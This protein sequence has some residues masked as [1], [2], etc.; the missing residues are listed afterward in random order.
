MPTASLVLQ[1]G[2][3]LGGYRILDVIGFGG[4]AVVYRAEQV[5]LNRIVALKVLSPELSRDPVFQERFRRE[6]KHVAA[7][8]H[9]NIIPIYDAAESDGRL[10]LAMR[11]VEGQTLAQ[12]MA[13]GGIG[14]DPTL[15][16][17]TP[18]AD[19]L[20]TAHEASVI[21]RDIKP[22]N[23]LLT[24]RDHPFLADF[25]VAKHVAGQGLTASGSF[26]GSVS[27][28]SPEQIRGEPLTGATDV[29]SLTA[30]LYQCL[31]G[32]VPYPLD[33][34]ASVMLAHLSAPP[35]ELPTTAGPLRDVIARG[36]AKAPE[37][38]YAT[39]GALLRATAEALA[40][41]S[42]LPD[43]TGPAFPAARAKAAAPRTGAAIDGA[44]LTAADVLRPAP[45]AAAGPSRGRGRRRLAIA[46]AGAV[47]AG[48]AIAALALTGSS[49]SSDSPPARTADAGPLR[50]TIGD[51][52]T[53]KPTG[54]VTFEGLQLDRAVALANAQA[55]EVR[56]GAGRLRN[57]GLQSG[58]L[59]DAT[60]AGFSTRP[61][62][63][64][65]TLGNVRGWRY[66]G[67]MAN[68]GST[69]IL[70]VPSSAGEVA[71]A[72]HVDAP[73][74]SALRGCAGAITDARLVGGRAL[75][76]GPDAELATGLAAALRPVR[77]R[78][79]AG[80]VSVADLTVRA[81]R[82][83]AVAKADAQAAAALTALHPS[84]WD[85]ATVKATASALTGEQGRLTALAAA[86]ATRDRQ[87]YN[88]ARAGLGASGRT[89]RHRLIALRRRGYAV[90]LPTTLRVPA[91]PQR[92]R[93]KHHATATPSTPVT[94]PSS[95][96]RDTTASPTPYVPQRA[97]PSPKATTK[98]TPKSNPDPIVIAPP[99]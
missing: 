55:P 90:A 70:V 95:G 5:A 6:G 86:I 14:L 16:I 88:K 85:A 96:T 12:R 7:L 65:T 50:L 42:D 97:T 17:L 62:P 67:P 15:A 80:A 61:R 68:G 43:G 25:G 27:Y 10:F 28:A 58:A 41:L 34:D 72:C 71:V 44:E 20:D 35:P 38:R 9:P 56:L 91:L 3:P 92:K 52:W 63:V 64:P 59:A 98:P 81:A 73:S 76:P 77:A 66:S 8:E 79:T 53:A 31:S 48:G 45:A 69:E 36:M 37:D 23:I 24:A 84:A 49:S 74:P 94:T 83:R 32:E 39:A 2:T 1:P 26:L 87:A 22:Q 89:L 13:D 54:D 21:H 47:I 19:A 29:Y 4:M 40:A 30:V 51:G 18:I 33:T 46:G 93:P 99:Q 82:A 57:T 60:L 75:A 11:F 78:R